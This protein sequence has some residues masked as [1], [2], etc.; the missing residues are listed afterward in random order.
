VGVKKNGLRSRARVQKNEVN[1]TLNHDPSI[2]LTSYQ[3]EGVKY[4][5]EKYICFEPV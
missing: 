2:K 4:L 5:N 3:M 1:K